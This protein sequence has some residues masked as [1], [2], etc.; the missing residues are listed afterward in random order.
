MMYSTYSCMEG[1]KVGLLYRIT[2]AGLGDI[3]QFSEHE[4][5][6]QPRYGTGQ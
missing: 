5:D 1:I 3:D 6:Q 2:R 4:E